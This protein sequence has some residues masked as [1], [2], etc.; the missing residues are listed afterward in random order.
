[1]SAALDLGW[2]H[3]F[4]PAQ[5]PGAS[6]LLLLH[7]TGGDEHSLLPLA[8][9]AAPDR[10]VLSVRGRSLEE[11]SPRFFRRLG[12]LSF[13]QD[14]IRSEA[15]AL[16]EFLRAASAAYSLDPARITALGYSNGANIGL[17]VLLLHPGALSGAA[18]LRPV[19]A[20][21][22]QPQADLSGKRLLTLQGRRDPYFAAGVEIAPHATSLG[23]EVTAHV[24]DAGHELIQADVALL[25]AWLAAEG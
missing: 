13:D 19:A 2:T 6:T 24:Q 23:A 18:L 16:A 8:Q 10:A 5:T 14:Q 20:L 12:S 3:L 11:G 25:S 22:P 9:A 15:A 7:G 21:R 4:R 1:M 17:A